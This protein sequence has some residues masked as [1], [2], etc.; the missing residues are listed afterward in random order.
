[1]AL[2]FYRLTAD[3][4]LAFQQAVT[5]FLDFSYTFLQA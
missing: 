2:G 1:L 5:S 4:R 3:L